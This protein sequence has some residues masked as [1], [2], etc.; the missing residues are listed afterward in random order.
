MAQVSRL[1]HPA[2]LLASGIKVKQP[3]DCIKVYSFANTVQTAL[4]HLYYWEALPIN[5]LTCS[6]QAVNEKL[7][8]GLSNL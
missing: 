6:S 5:E 2:R 7:C 1:R 8:R 3:V 4:V